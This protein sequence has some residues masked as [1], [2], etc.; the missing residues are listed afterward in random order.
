MGSGAVVALWAWLGL[1]AFAADP[2]T[3][4][5]TDPSASGVG[6]GKGPIETIQ[7]EVEKEKTEEEIAAEARLAEFNAAN[8]D[9]VARIVVI[10]WPETDV[11]YTNETLQRNIRNRIART[12]AKFFPDVDLYQAGRVEP[13]KSV[14]P[15]DQ[16]A[17]VPAEVIPRVLAA[18]EDTAAIP[19]DGMSEQNWGIRANEL[20]QLADEMWFI[21]RVE[22]REPTFLLYAQIGRAAESSNQGSPPFFANINGR[23]VN[24]Y[25]YL[26]GTL[27]FKDPALLSKLT[28]QDLYQSIAYY[29]DELDAGRFEPLTVSFDLDGEF[30]AKEFLAEYQVFVNGAEETITSQSGL[31]KVPLGKVDIYLKRSDGHSLSDSNAFYDLPDSFHFVRQNARKR[32]GLDFKDQLMENPSECMPNLS[33][34]IV[35]YLSIY[36]K[37]HPT[38]DIFV[39]LPFLGSTQ[40]GRIHLWRWDR[41]RSALL[42]LQD[43]TGGFPIRFAAVLTVGASFSGVTLTPPEGATEV[44]T[45]QTPG[46]EPDPAAASALQPKPELNVEGV[47]VAYQ[48]RGHY[49]RLL[50]GVGLQYKISATGDLFVDEYQTQGG[51]VLKP[52]ED[53]VDV[54]SFRE[55]KLQRLV[56]AMFGVVLG[57]DAAVGFGPRGYI[58]TGWYNAPHAVDITGHVGLTTTVP[59][60]KKDEERIGRVRALLDVDLYAGAVAP[61]QDSLY[62]S[63]TGLFA[64]GKPFFNFGLTAGVGLTF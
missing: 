61:V 43:N 27:A 62:V 58:R 7:E 49:N 24:Y 35:N 53:G 32:M 38:N 36:A 31:L 63:E 6:G 50:M 18:V 25:W 26:A 20:L 22:L 59:G 33:G 19:Y 10:Q 54:A 2:P 9:P 56:F 64:V 45:G 1:S 47:P 28:T 12:D 40:P 14:R 42:L 51:T 48:L 8:P 5:L 21:D 44:V 23:S 52:G 30:D 41:A 3:G 4:S 37:L 17:S 15:T 13:D 55:R 46:A 11:D 29:K 39:A 57:K 34:D 16:R 60:N